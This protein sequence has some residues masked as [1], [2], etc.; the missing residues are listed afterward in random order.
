MGFCTSKP[1]AGFIKRPSFVIRLNP[2]PGN[3]VL[4]E[5]IADFYIRVGLVTSS[6][7]SFTA[8]LI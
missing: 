8:N 5:E 4:P 7:I 3:N 1:S 2:V 6:S